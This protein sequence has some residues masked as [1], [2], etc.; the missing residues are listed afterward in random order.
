MP[1]IEY[2]RVDASKMLLKFLKWWLQQLT[3]KIDTD[4]NIICFININNNKKN[5][6]FVILF[7]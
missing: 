4:N 2:G 7:N 3:N 6:K 1:L 5:L